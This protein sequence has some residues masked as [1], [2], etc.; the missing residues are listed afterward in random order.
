MDLSG[1]CGQCLRLRVKY[2]ACYNMSDKKSY[3]VFF[4]YLYNSSD[5]NGVKQPVTAGIDCGQMQLLRTV[6]N[7]NIH[8]RACTGRR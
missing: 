2:L 6:V 5:N 8:M 1:F 7:T 4:K 3:L